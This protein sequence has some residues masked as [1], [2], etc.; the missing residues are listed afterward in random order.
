M[1][2]GLMAPSITQIEI[3]SKQVYSGSGWSQWRASQNVQ[4]PVCLL[5]LA[6]P[7]PLAEGRKL[8]PACVCPKLAGLSVPTHLLEPPSF[9]WFLNSGFFF[10]RL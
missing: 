3:L 1:A 5:C 7:L 4:K 10:T 8:L 9:G 2:E 6:Q